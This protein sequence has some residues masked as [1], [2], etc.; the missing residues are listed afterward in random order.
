MHYLFKTRPLPA[1]NEPEAETEPVENIAETMDD[2]AEAEDINEEEDVALVEEEADTTISKDDTVDPAL[3][4][5]VQQALA[6][7]EEDDPA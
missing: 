3:K 4:A 1:A 5:R 7:L 2:Q 6:E